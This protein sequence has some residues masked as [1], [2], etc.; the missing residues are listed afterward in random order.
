ML[1]FRFPNKDKDPDWWVAWYR[2]C[3]RVKHPGKGVV[4]CSAHFEEAGINRDCSNRLLPD[5]V[6]TIFN[7]PN[8]L[9]V[10][11]EFD[12]KAPVEVLL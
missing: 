8:H 6:P 5:A 4:V 10:H 1:N 2:N 9:Q 11:S 3:R 12:S 7:L